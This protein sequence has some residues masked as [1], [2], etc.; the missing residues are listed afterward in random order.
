MPRVLSCLPHCPWFL[1]AV[2]ASVSRQLMLAGLR[3]GSS[4]RTGAVGLKSLGL[5]RPFLY[6]SWGYRSD[7][8]LMPNAGPPLP[9]SLL[10]SDTRDFATVNSE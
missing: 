6:P 1:M 7:I 3:I 10:S 8:Q 9:L 2:T 5:R 4:S